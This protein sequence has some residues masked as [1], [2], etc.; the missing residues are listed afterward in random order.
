[1]HR[2]QHQIRCRSLRSRIRLLRQR[3]PLARCLRATLRRRPPPPQHP[4]SME[5]PLPGTMHQ[6]MHQGL[7]ERRGS[8]PVKHP[9]TLQRMVRVHHTA[10]AFHLPSPPQKA[11]QQNLTLLGSQL[12]WLLTKMCQN[13]MKRLMKLTFRRVQFRGMRSTSRKLFASGLET[14][15]K[16]VV[17]MASGAVV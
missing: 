16:A 17:V 6:V 7:L 4:A 5:R 10:P 9:L 11:M 15:P 14:A 13:S 2:L 1:M 12:M 8:A 3:W